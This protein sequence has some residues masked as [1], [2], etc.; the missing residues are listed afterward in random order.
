MKECLH[1][2]KNGNTNLIAFWTWV[3]RTLMHHP[4][5]IRNRKQSVFP[6]SA[7]EEVMPP[8]L[9]GPSCH[10][11]PFAVSYDGMLGNEAKVVLQNLT[12]SLAKKSGKSY[13]LLIRNFKFH[14]VKAEHCNCT[15]YISMHPRI[16]HPTMG[17]LSQHPQWE[18]G[19]GTIRRTT[20]LSLN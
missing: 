12:P 17:R 18:D 16:K 19:A 15:R 2:K 5:F 9:S 20:T 13:L 3:S 4:T 11:S 1:Q 7:K 14:K 10:F 6:M 8:G